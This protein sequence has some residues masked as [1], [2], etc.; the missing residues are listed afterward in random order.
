MSFEDNYC[1]FT[2]G[3]DSVSAAIDTDYSSSSNSAGTVESII[4]IG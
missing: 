3:T 2:F 4:A 1:T